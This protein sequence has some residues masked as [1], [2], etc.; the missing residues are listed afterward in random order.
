LQA[1]NRVGFAWVLQRL[2]KRSEA[3]AELRR[4]V[5]ILEGLAKRDP[6]DIDVRQY[7]GVAL[8]TQGAH[9]LEMGDA[10]GVEKDLQRS[11]GLLE[12]LYQQNPRKLMLLRD[13]ADCYQGFGDLCASRSNWKQAQ[14]WYRKS[15][16]LWERWKRVGVSSVYDRQ[17][18]D[19]AASLVAQVA[20]KSSKSSPSR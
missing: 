5:E 6:N 10:G 17:R 13:L 8:Q 19:H 1:F 4:A 7:L 18:G 14:A 20:K 12:L 3:L 16:D 15:L 9:R 2:G 11:L